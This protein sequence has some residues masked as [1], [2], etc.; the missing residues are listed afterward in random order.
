M[1]GW[2]V[3][4]NEWIEPANTLHQTYCSCGSSGTNYRFSVGWFTPVLSPKLLNGFDNITSP[5]FN[6]PWLTIQ[7]IDQGDAVAFDD[8]HRICLLDLSQ[9][10]QY[11]LRG[12]TSFTMNVVD[13][14]PGLQKLILDSA[15]PASS[16]N[17]LPRNHS[18]WQLFGK[19]G[20]RAS[21]NVRELS[22]LV[23]R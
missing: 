22:A 21:D 2:H 8:R 6:S 18:K 15:R 1:S 9:P 20:V 10:V 5:V 17:G 16:Y 19:L 23:F 11:L 12:V 13:L 4:Y 14:C 3:E 7:F